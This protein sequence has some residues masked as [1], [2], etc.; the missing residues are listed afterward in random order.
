MIPRPDASEH[1]PYYRKYV[2]L[3]PDGDLATMLRAQLDE[4]LALVRG[5]PEEQGGHRYAPGKWSI[6]EVLGHV[7]DTERVFA[8][9]ALR[10]ARGDATPLEGFDENAYAAASG[11]DGRTLADLAQE[12]EH[13]RLGNVAFLRALGDEALARRGTANGAE[14][15]VR[16]LA[17]I[18]AGHELHHRGL[19]RERYLAGES[20]AAGA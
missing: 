15:T 6:R 2:D 17:W 13:V 20:A 12:L 7:I 3:V 16:A 14:V 18:L 8:Y 11:A 9:R 4:T 10:I 1:L 5:L 19:L